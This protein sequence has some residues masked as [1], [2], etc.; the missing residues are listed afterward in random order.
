MFR[1]DERGLPAAQD[2][3][4][5]CLQCA[6]TDRVRAPVLGSASQLHLPHVQLSLQPGGTRQLHALRSTGEH[7]G[8]L[9]RH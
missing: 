4:E 9:C 6:H 2:R 1:Q 8:L 5:A 3:S 7:V